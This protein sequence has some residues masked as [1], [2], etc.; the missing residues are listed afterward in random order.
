MQF[1]ENCRFVF[2]GNR[3]PICDSK[4][5]RPVQDDDFCFL[6]EKSAAYS[7]VLTEI[8]RENDIPCSALP[9]TRGIEAYF[10]LPPENNRL[11]VPFHSLE[12]AKAFLRKTE[13]AETE[14][15]RECLLRNAGNLHASQK[16]EKKARK[17]IK[18]S[19][20]GD[21][22]GYFV[23]IVV[24][25]CFKT[26]QKTGQNCPVFTNKI[27][28]EGAITSC[29]KGGHYLFCFSDTATISVNSETYEILSL[30]IP[31]TRR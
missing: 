7:A 4:K 21:F 30:T 29:T 8:F 15:W 24:C 6:T 20:D 26:S 12:K 23:E 11:Y 25:Y 1:C 10:A 27:A 9:H 17:K 16:F 3:C 19:E 18:L 5:S 14:A 22:F 13:N 2:E 28:D 31:K